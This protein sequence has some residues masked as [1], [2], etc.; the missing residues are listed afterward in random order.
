MRHA[1]PEWAEA[2]EENKQTIRGKIQTHSHTHTHCQVTA[3]QKAS[4]T[5]SSTKAQK[6]CEIKPKKRGKN[7]A[8]ANDN[9]LR[10]N[11]AKKFCTPQSFDGQEQTLNGPKG[12]AA[13]SGSNAAAI[14]NA[15]MYEWVCVCVNFFEL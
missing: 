10:K 1:S 8:T 14:L 15:H 2:G 3:F 13:L 12:Y 6:L 5:P 9:K 11:K 7:T 4:K